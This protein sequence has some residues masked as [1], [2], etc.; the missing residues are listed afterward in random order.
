[1]KKFIISLIF[2]PFVTFSSNLVLTN[3]Q[4]NYTIAKNLTKNTRIEVRDLFN[5]SQNMYSNQNIAMSNVKNSE[6]QSA[7]AV[8]SLDKVWDED[9]IYEYARRHN[10]AVINIDATYSYRDNTSLA[11]AIKSYDSMKNKIN[12]YV[13]LNLF[14]LEKM[15][16][17]VALDFMSIFP[18]QKA[19]IQLNLDNNLKKLHKLIASYN[20]VNIDSAILLT[21]DLQYLAGFLNIYYKNE[22]YENISKDNILNILNEEQIDTVLTSKPLKKEIV[23]VLKE[24]NKNYVLLNTGAYP[25]EDDNDEDKMKENGLDIYLTDNLEK[26][27]EIK[28]KKY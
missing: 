2:L 1:M 26:L 5:T 6:Y 3:N 24:N 13:W 10:I 19:K 8:I 21:E 11:L 16:K 27:K 28:W 22:K 4:V 14:N 23:N 20:K 12:P 9:S 17:I 7:V 18:K 25:L 15:Y